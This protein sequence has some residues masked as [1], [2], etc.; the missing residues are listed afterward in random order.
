MVGFNVC[1]RQ[2]EASRLRERSK[3]WAYF[4]ATPPPGEGVSASHH[5]AWNW[6]VDANLFSKLY[7]SHQFKPRGDTC[8]SKASTPVQSCTTPTPLCLQKPAKFQTQTIF[9][10][11]PSFLS[12][13]KDESDNLQLKIAWMTL[14]SIVT[15][16]MY[17]TIYVTYV[18]MSNHRRAQILLHNFVLSC[19]QSTLLFCW[20]PDCIYYTI[21]I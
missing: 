10:A 21:C 18:C 20:M 6:F 17:N 7:S 2:G 9:L 16:L 19:I 8:K 5:K 15:R 3:K 13:S 11:Q 1:T 4:R 12:H 14:T